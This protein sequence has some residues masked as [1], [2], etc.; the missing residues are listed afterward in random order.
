[1]ALG[2]NLSAP[3]QQVNTALE[4]LK[5]LPY[6]RFI[7]CSS[8]YRS[9]PLGPK[10]QPDFLNAVVAL[11]TT[12]DPETLLDY[13]QKIELRQ[14]RIR[15]EHRFGARTLDLDI[16]LFADRII[17]T[18]RLTVPHYDMHNREFTLYPLAELA[19]NLVLPD[20]I[21][22][23]KHLRQVPLNGLV[24]WDEEHRYYKK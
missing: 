3:L 18:A 1:M 7:A 14:G 11:D 17:S 12:L 19:P 16:L 15:K 4:A 22:L 2:S 21:A 9:Y 8:Y 24:Y 6:T 13:I 10:D 23:A 20:G 5:S